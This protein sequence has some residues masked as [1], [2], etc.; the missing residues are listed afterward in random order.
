MHKCFNHPSIFLATNWKPNLNL[1]L[2]MLLFLTSGYWNPPPI[3][4]SF[5]NFEFLIYVGKISPVKKRLLGFPPPPPPLFF[6]EKKNHWKKALFCDLLSRQVKGLI[7]NLSVFLYGAFSQLG[8]K[9]KILGQII[10]I[11]FHNF[12]FSICHVLSLDTR[13][14]QLA[15][16]W[17][18]S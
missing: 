4:T 18:V 2:F 14:Q 3:I 7:T 12:F 13:A 11:V 15:K 9:N 10:Q 17:H 1:A 8:N 6:I 5:L 16:I